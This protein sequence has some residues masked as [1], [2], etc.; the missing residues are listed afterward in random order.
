[1]N[2]QNPATILSANP[3]EAENSLGDWESLKSRVRY[4]PRDVV[5]ETAVRLSHWVPGHIME[6]GVY[7]G[8]STR[9]LRRT[10]SQCKRAEFGGP[11]KRIYAC[12]SFQGLPEKFAELEAGTFA[13]DPPRIRG[14]KIVKG[15]FEDSLTPELADE[16]RQV[17]LA[18]LDADLY[19]STAC[20]LNW[21]TPMLGTGSLLLFDQ[22]LGDGSAEKKAFDDWQRETGIQTAKIA[23]FV[24][25]PSGRGA[26]LDM[27]ALFQVVGQEKINPVPPFW[28]WLM[29]VKRRLGVGFAPGPGHIDL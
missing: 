16:V 24:R 2:D 8:T 7:R 22:F 19:S 12:D 15:Y 26:N 1:M 9:I 3:S 29:K 6:F 10:L 11:A 27:R 13:C 25:A 5:L 17:A 23:E 14:V 4:V 28:D 21:L 20:V 18:S